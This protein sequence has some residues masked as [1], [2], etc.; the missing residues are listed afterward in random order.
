MSSESPN[1][2]SRAKGGMNLKPGSFFPPIK[3]NDFLKKKPARIFFRSFYTKSFL[4]RQEFPYL[5]LWSLKSNCWIYK[6]QIGCSFCSTWRLMLLRFFVPISPS[7]WLLYLG[8]YGGH[9]CRADIGMIYFS[10]GIFKH[11]SPK[12]F[13]TPKWNFHRSSAAFVLYPNPNWSPIWKPRIR[14]GN[15]LRGGGRLFNIFSIFKVFP[16]KA[17]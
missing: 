15:H 4:E 11:N 16:P 8:H 17:L 9:S 10:A 14:D 7:Q 3:P 12:Y 1:L 2:G 6:L 13:Q 5:F